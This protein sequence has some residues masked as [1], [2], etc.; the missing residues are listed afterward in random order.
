M[1]VGVCGHGY[2]G[3]GAVLD[4]LKQFD[5]CSVPSSAD[6]E[7]YLAYIPH[8]IQDLEYNL[9]TRNVRYISS[10]AAIK[11]FI[12]MIKIL[13]TPKSVYRIFGGRKFKELSQDFIKDLVQ[14]QWSGYATYDRVLMNSLERILRFRVLH[15]LRRLYENTFSKRCPLPFQENMYL[16][17]QPRDFYEK[18]RDYLYNVLECLNY[19]LKKIVVLNQPFEANTPKNSMKFFGD[20]KA[21]VVERDP[22]DVYVFVKKFLFSKGSFIPTSNVEDFIRYWKLVRTKPLPSYESEGPDILRIQ[23]EDLIYN[24]ES[25]SSTIKLFLGLP[26]KTDNEFRFFVPQKSL[27][28]TQLFQRYSEFKQDIEKIEQALPEY[29]YPFDRVELSPQN[30]VTPF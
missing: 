21:I 20:A 9:M 2:T 3:S 14:V 12:K 18:V 11:E 7:F 24:Y 17:V 8:G 1:V 6:Y 16:S 28:N 22:R 26:T 25:I 19:D 13:D 4:F 29:L 30:N 15:R 5:E 10:N 23:F 27:N